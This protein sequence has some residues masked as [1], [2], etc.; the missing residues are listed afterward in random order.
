[1]WFWAWK[2]YVTSLI[3]LCIAGITRRY[4]DDAFPATCWPFD[5]EKW[6]NR[7]PVKKILQKYWEFYYLR[8][9][10]VMNLVLNTPRLDSDTIESANRIPLGER[11]CYSSGS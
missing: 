1:M 9:A 3:G 10:D 7:H 6:E 11:D 2:L 4:H 8:H 5:T